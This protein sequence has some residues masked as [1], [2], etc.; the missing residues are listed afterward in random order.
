M[1]GILISHQETLDTLNSLL[2]SDRIPHGLLL[3]GPEGIGKSKVAYRLQHA[4]LEGEQAISSHALEHNTP[5]GQLLR[6][7]VHPDALWMTR[8]TNEKTGKLSQ[9]I[10]VEEARKVTAFFQRK[11]ALSKR[12]IVVVDAV[13]DLNMNGAN[14]LLKVLEEPP[15]GATLI[16]IAHR[17]SKV[18]PTLRSRSQ[19]I[20]LRALSSEEL[21]S[22]VK[23]EFGT[24][25]PDESDALV[26]L[27]AG[28]PGCAKMLYDQGGLEV[29][30]QFLTVV[31]A[32]NTPDFSAVLNDFV[33]Q[34]T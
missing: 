22:F 1:S 20:S 34:M 27:S 8:K 6:S 9:G 18:L 13:D 15:V 31:K 12:R 16:L 29:F 10:S 28:S 2:K 17:M 11:P 33:A 3:V 30:D 19:M 14:A 26:A 7:G 24:L 32:L 25:S 5:T 21:K 4:L 23:S